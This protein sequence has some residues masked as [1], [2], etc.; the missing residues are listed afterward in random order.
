MLRHH[1]S[2]R[3]QDSYCSSNLRSTYL[4][5]LPFYHSCLFF[6]MS[7]LC[8]PL[9]SSNMALLEVPHAESPCPAPCD[10]V[11]ELHSFL[12]KQ[13]A[14]WGWKTR[15]LL[16]VNNQQEQ[17]EAI[18]R[19]L[20]VKTFLSFCKWISRT[21]TLEHG[22]KRATGEVRPEGN[23]VL[24]DWVFGRLPRQVQVRVH[25]CCHWIETRISSLPKGSYNAWKN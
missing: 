5:L 24:W 15:G 12:W 20:A 9:S 10:S 13:A 6:I 19:D 23:A 25:L 16:L 22:L 14:A 3:L 17:K 7:E 2:G 11:M 18:G 1:A 4:S 21:V 8:S